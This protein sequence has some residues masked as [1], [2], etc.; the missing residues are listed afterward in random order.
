MNDTYASLPQANQLL[1]LPGNAPLTLIL[2]GSLS[3]TSG[4]HLDG[5]ALIFDT[6]LPS[7]SFY[8]GQDSGGGYVGNTVNSTI[9]DT[10]SGPQNFINLMTV[11][12]SPTSSIVLGFD[13]FSPNSA[14]NI[15]GAIDLSTNGADVFLGTAT[16]ATY[17]GTITPFAN[18]FQFSG[19]KGGQVTVTSASLTGVNSVV[20]GLS[21]P[22]ESYGSI[23]SVIL[24]NANTYSSGTTLNSGY[25][26]VGNNDS[27]GSGTLLVSTTNAAVG[28]MPFGGS[29]TLPNNVAV[30]YT[31]LQLNYTGSPYT[32]TLAGA[33]SDAYGAGQLYING[34]VT[35]S[36]NSTYS[37]TTTVNDTTLTVGSANGLG[38]SALVATAGSTIH[39]TAV[40][41]VVTQLSLT[42]ASADFSYAGGSPSLSDVLLSAGSTLTFANNST[43]TINGFN[44]DEPNSG[45]IINIGTG[46]VLT[47]ELGVD[48]DYNG[49][50]AGNGALVVDGDNL[51][52]R[53]VNTYSGGT[54]ITS[55]GSITASNSSAL[56]IAGVTVSGGLALN[57]GVTL[58]NPITLTGGTLAGYGTFSPG[59][60]LTIQGGSLLAPGI[61]TVAV[62]A[63]GTNVPAVGTLTF[64]GGTSLTFAHTL[65]TGGL[66]FSIADA[67]GTSG[68]GFSL[69]NISGSLTITATAG[70]EFYIHLYSFDPGTNQ[71]GNAANFN[72]GQG[73]S[74]LLV[75]TGSGV[76]NFSSS[77]FII[78]QSNFT[79]STGAGQFS[80][81]QSGND[82]M[83]NF[84]PVPEPSTWALMA[85]GLL[86]LGAVVR[87]RRR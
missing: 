68:S 48:P 8:I 53:G 31:G 78:D 65:N 75:S 10:G 34:P 23:S 15:S 81:S 41:P 50:I 36:G 43:P 22:L 80:V 85:T 87:R 84:T 59:G 69:L 74:W 49:T 76:S 55:T 4:T 39:F 79:N 72:G 66:N 64:G 2:S 14:R 32:L 11:A 18:T 26:Y 44:S 56:G 16:A 13:Y 57:T 40:S 60:N 1:V 46:A 29:V 21:S 58:T 42:G 9:T 63:G 73:Y 5:A 3:Y 52:L 27:L 61:A 30:P 62:D 17:S 6:P 77:A 51:N 70:S 24:P 38:Q 45:N 7:S 82:L 67:N 86:T 25:L 35:L 47:F 37:G 54:T 28:L 71:A 20:I 12:G 83:L 19:V 33:I